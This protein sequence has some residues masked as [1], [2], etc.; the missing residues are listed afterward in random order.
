MCFYEFYEGQI[1][2]DDCDICDFFMIELWEK[3]GLV[4]QDVFMFYGD[5]VGNICLL[6]LNII[7]E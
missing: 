2:I 3:M 1:L 5:I 4:L 7:D 6:N